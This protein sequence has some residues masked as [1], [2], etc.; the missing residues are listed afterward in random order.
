MERGNSYRAATRR[1]LPSVEQLCEG[2]NPSNPIEHIVVCPICGQMFDCRD[3]GAV[4]HHSR[5]QHNPQLRK[6]HADA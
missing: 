4:R 2:V 3:Q 6:P 1:R 5:D